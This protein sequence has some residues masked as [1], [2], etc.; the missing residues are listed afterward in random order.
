MRHVL[1]QMIQGLAPA[2]SLPLVGDQ[3]A[4][5]RRATVINAIRDGVRSYSDEPLLAGVPS[6]PQ[7]QP[8]AGQFFPLLFDPATTN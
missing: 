3:T 8:L 7:G 5:P 4:V 1:G 6:I 2:L